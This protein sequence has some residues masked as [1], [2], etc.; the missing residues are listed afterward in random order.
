MI[1][2]SSPAD[3]AEI[4]G[5]HVVASLT[6]PARLDSLAPSDGMDDGADGSFSRICRIAA[7]AL[8]APT[9]R[10][11]V[12]T[13]DHQVVRGLVGAGLLSGRRS[14]PPA[15][16]FCRHV[17][18]TG[19]PLAVDDVYRLPHDPACHA[20]PDVRAYL[21]VPIRDDDGL[22][23]GALCVADL[24][25]RQWTARDREALLDIA[26]LVP[27]SPLRRDAGTGRGDE[28]D[29]ALRRSEARLRDLVKA[30]PDLFLRLTRGGRYLDVRTADPALL[31]YDEAALPGWTVEESLPEPVAALVLDAIG[32]A[33][34]TG[35]LQQIEYALTHADGRTRRYEARLVPVGDDDVQAI[36]RDVTAQYEAAQ[37]L[38]ESE[39]R[40]RSFIEA[41]TQVAWVANADGE[42]TELNDAWAEFTGQT[43][44]QI[45][46]WGW[47]DAVHPDDAA[48]VAESWTAAI[49]A[50]AD[51]EIEYRIRSRDGHY[52]RF[53]VRGVAVSTDEAFLGWVGTCTDVE[54]A[55]SHEAELVEAARVA[56]AGRA[57]AEEA[58]RMKS[59]LLANLSHE[60]RTPL[61]S[62]IGFA[63]LLAE[64]ATSRRLDE[65]Q[66]CAQLIGQGGRRLL[67]TL[68]SVLDLAQMEAGRRELRLDCLDVG[69]VVT[70]TANL[71]RPLAEAEGLALRCDVPAEPV[72]A[73]ADRGALSRAVTN[74]VSNAVKFT[75]EGEVRVALDAGPVALTLTVSD[76]GVGMSE[77]F[78]PAAF[79][80][81]RQE[82]EGHT[83]RFEGNGLGLAI[84]RRLVEMLG[85]QIGVESE[86]GVGTTFTIRLPRSGP[87]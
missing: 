69:E 23:I 30:V 50:Q 11:S 58:A 13:D 77:A 6:E 85:G 37:A 26:A 42:V 70:E 87:A 41:T 2:T 4:P 51:F 40:F 60:I 49:T 36:V 45:A 66:E 25:A 21:G 22:V 33:L 65:R 78:L 63:D 84:T 32:R 1:D 74:L 52:H 28:A 19:A 39:V 86:L 7:R 44:D 34:D 76:T 3:R 55:R 62:I 48:G 27:R 5:G 24:A 57:A 16:S 47:A 54:A 29:R 71:L 64:E 8:Q 81:F 31:L 38:R 83:R 72:V 68:T 82:S 53:A 67:E 17:V 12:F 80:E 10:V 14:S 20:G 75:L 61:T 46:G 9:A 15:P 56:E 79:D 35:E 18:A 73:W 43:P 59:A